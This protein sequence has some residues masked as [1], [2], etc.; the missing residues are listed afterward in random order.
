MFCY[1]VYRIHL[2]SM[3]AQN[4]LEIQEKLRK[5]EATL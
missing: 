3:Q 5:T 1:K 4:E 2:T